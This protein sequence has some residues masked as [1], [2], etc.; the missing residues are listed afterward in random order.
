MIL[1]SYHSN[2][3]GDAGAKMLT[4]A[5]KVNTNLQILSLH[6]MGPIPRHVLHSLTIVVQNVLMELSAF[7]NDIRYSI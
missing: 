5:V 2:D 4:E 3:I 1:L 6:S 7:L